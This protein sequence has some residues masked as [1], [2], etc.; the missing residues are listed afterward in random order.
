MWNTSLFCYQIRDY[1]FGT[2]LR[3]GQVL[4]TIVVVFIVC[5]AVGYL[6]RRY[7]KR[8]KNAGGCTCENMEC[9]LQSAG[10]VPVEKPCEG[11]VCESKKGKP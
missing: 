11:M 8:S 4:D 2:V 7:V 5:L 9:P 6:V 10:S 1:P 3:E